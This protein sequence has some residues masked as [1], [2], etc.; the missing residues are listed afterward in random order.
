[1]ALTEL[2]WLGVLLVVTL[3]LWARH[4]W[5][6]RRYPDRARP[7]AAAVGRSPAG[8]GSAVRCSVRAPAARA[9]TRRS[10]AA[11]GRAVNGLCQPRCHRYR[12]HDSQH[13]LRVQVRDPA[14]R[15]VA[16]DVGR[17]G[18]EVT[19]SRAPCPPSI[20]AA[21]SGA[22][23]DSS[24]PVTTGPCPSGFIAP[25]CTVPSSSR[26]GKVRPA[27]AR[28]R[29]GPAPGLDPPDDAA[30]RIYRSL[31]RGR[32]GARSGHPRGQERTVSCSAVPPG[33]APSRLRTR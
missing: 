28:R 11:G 19:H 7:D 16:A 9:S 22:S 10:R 18:E 8:T 17:P 20:R 25:L 6:I 29:G 33:P 24:P 3:A 5:H 13:V 12:P 1:M 30:Q 4:E 26:T 21:T 15:P 31:K 14:Q 23:S 27:L 2:E 32:A